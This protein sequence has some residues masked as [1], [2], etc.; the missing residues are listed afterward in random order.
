V[1]DRAKEGK[2]FFSVVSADSVASMRVATILEKHDPRRV[3][4]LVDAIRRETETQWSQRFGNRGFWTT[5]DNHR[6][7]KTVLAVGQEAAFPLMTL[8]SGRV[9]EAAVR[10]ITEIP[11][12]FCFALLV[13]RMNDWVAEVRQ[14]AEKKLAATL[15][16]IAAETVVGCIELLWDFERFRRSSPSARA[17]VENLLCD[18]VV[19]GML[20]TE[21]RASTSDRA[22]RVLHQLLRTPVLD[23]DLSAVATTCR[24]PNVRAVAM[25][26]L[27]EQ[28]YR[29]RD[30]SGPHSRAITIATDRDALAR[31]ALEDR[32]PKVQL[33]GLEFAVANGG[34][35]QDLESILL[36]FAAHSTNSLA[37]LAQWKLKA[38]GVDWVNEVRGKLFNSDGPNH[39]VARVL[40]I[41]GDESDGNR[42]W[43]IATEL[44]DAR[45]MPFLGAAA[46]LKNASAAGRLRDIVNR[47]SRLDLARRASRTLLEAKISLPSEDLKAWADRGDEFIAR[48]LGRHFAGLTVMEQLLVL[49]RLEKARA[50]FDLN[51]WFASPSKKRNRGLFRP[52]EADMREFMALSGH[53]P[54]VHERAQRLIGVGYDSGV[55]NT[56]RV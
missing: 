17:I 7:A 25:R 8:W 26:V 40:G 24:H 49:C 53:C 31:Q 42:L 9:R 28:S 10:A 20:R 30:T 13:H 35:W 5:G 52:S 19:L 27:L 36:A 32:A 34:S 1:F 38:I 44:S 23:G 14:A 21:V 3:S 55:P 2:G 15:G 11:G 12:S 16:S 45:A 51:N 41:S 50:N 47:S 37:E 29:W 4:V 39:R 18:P 54:H 48:G 22:H 33:A 6:L 46:R 43:S 56:R